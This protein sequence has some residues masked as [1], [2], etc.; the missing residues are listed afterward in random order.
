MRSDR[1][2]AGLVLMRF[3][4]P[5]THVMIYSEVVHDARIVRIG[6]RHLPSTVQL[7][8]GDSIGRREGETQVVDTTNF[9]EHTHFRYPDRI[10]TLSRASDAPARPRSITRSRWTTRRRE[11]D[12]GARMCRSARVPI[13][14]MS[15]R[16]TRA[17]TQ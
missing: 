13:A 16:V 5:P 11:R 6:G 1:A 12:R 7:W 10:C 9:I 14:C 17:I 8:L 3:K 4:F 15:M 2:S